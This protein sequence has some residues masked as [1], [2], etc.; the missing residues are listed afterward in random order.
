MLRIADPYI[1]WGYPSQKIIRQLVYKRGYVK[2]NNQRQPLTD[3][4]IVERNLGKQD[5]I[6]VEDMI[7]QVEGIFKEILNLL[8]N[9]FLNFTNF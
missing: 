2:E 4:N 1:A 6:C 7:H 5:V 8:K 9:R 3:N